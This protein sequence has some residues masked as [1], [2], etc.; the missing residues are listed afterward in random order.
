VSRTLARLTAAAT[1]AALLSP[2]AGAWAARIIP[3]DAVK[4]AVNDKVVT[5]RETEQLRELQEQEYRQQ[6]KG[7]ELQQKLATLD[8]DLVKRIIEDLLM[9]A[10]AARLQIEVSDKDIEERVDN[11]LRRQPN[12][13]DL[14]TDEQLKSFVL[15]D[16]LRRRVLAREVDARVR[17]T[18]A[19][20]AAACRKQTQDS[21]EVDVGHILIRGDSEEARRTIEEVRQEL[22]AGGD[23]DAL[24]LKYSQDPSVATNKGH[25]GFIGHGQFV[26]AFE[27]T[28]FALPLGAVSQPVRTEFG[29]HIIKVFDQRNKGPVNCDKL[30]D[31]T[32]QTLE[33][34]VYTQLREAQL[35]DFLARARQLADIRVFDP[36]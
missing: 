20:I 13:Q 29:M 9:E 33:N 5:M 16:I 30:D 31:V 2:G 6:F 22:L 3:M 14:Y 10:H 26:K 32:R 18:D 8:E 27:D 12:I 35:Q 4:I 11:I 7:E 1:V 36:Q 24:A 25:L 19:D 21:R 28:A 17:V 23:F 15:K 34:Q